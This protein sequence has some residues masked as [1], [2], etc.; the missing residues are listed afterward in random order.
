MAA[1]PMAI[2]TL[3]I[4]PRWGELRGYSGVPPHLPHLPAAEQ[5]VQTIYPAHGM[6]GLGAHGMLGLGLGLGLG[7]ML[8]T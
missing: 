4:L 6:L 3:A 5:H 8:A 2:L 7:W 1:L